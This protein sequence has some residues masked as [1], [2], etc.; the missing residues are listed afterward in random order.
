M[1]NPLDNSTMLK[2]ELKSYKASKGDGKRQ[3]ILFSSLISCFL[4][5]YKKPSAKRKR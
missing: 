2:S 3:K 1:D 4:S 5:N